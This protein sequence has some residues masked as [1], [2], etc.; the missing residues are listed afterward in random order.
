M[1]NEDHLKIIQQGV[2]AWNAWREAYP[3]VTPDL[4]EASFYEANLSGANLSGALLARANF[5]TANLSGANL[6]EAHLP[7]ADLRGANLSRATLRGAQLPEATLLRA[8]LSGAN[9]AHAKLSAADLTHANLTDANLCEAILVRAMLVSTNLEKADLSGAIVYGTSVWDVN[10]VGAKQNNLVIT[11]HNV[12]TITVDNLEVAQFVYL[13]LTNK[14]IR[15][16]IDTIG[17]K[18][19]LILGR[20][21]PAR[22]AV[23]DAL[24]ESLRRRNF[25]PIL[26]DFEKPSSKNLTETVSTLAHLARFVIADL[27]DA[28]SIPQELQH[29]VPGLPSLPVQPLILSSQY[30]YALF[31]DFLD[32]DWVLLP[33]RYDSLDDLLASLEEKVIAPAIAK[34]EEITARRKAIEEAMRK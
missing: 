31:K 30:E 5:F 25:L 13:L 14:K 1:A 21:T 20:F 32:Y 12:P 10:A 9:L 33:H 28:K 34:A 17:K 22:K 15:D 6:S 19:V 26:F 18:A 29:I 27:T 8:N 11:L 24:R 7:K 4:R 23:L 2:D 3:D 16:V